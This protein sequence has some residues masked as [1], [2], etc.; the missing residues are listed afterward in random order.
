MSYLTANE[1][2]AV[3]KEKIPKGL[4]ETAHTSEGHFYRHTPT[5]E[6]YASVTTKSGILDAPHL[7]SWA[8]REAVKLITENQNRI[9]ELVNIIENEAP[10]EDHMKTQDELDKIYKAAIMAHKAL[11]EDAGDIGTQGHEA[12]ERY[13]NIWIETGK[14]PQDIRKFIELP[15]SRLH[16]IARSAEQFCIDFEV[17]P[18]ISELFVA[19]PR[20]KF[21]GQLDALMMIPRTVREGK[22]GCAHNWMMSPSRQ[23]I[24]R[25]YECDAKVQMELT[26]VDW[27][28][29]NRVDKP[30]YAMQVSAYWWGFY[31]LTGIRIKNI[32]IVRLDKDKMK[33]EVVKVGN[34]S[35]SFAAFRQVSKVHEWLNDGNDKLISSNKKE[36]ISLDDL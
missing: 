18:V 22:P 24:S 15:D 16:A 9:S 4:V 3:I 32:I 2:R 20:Y 21:A 30:E 14:R 10:I 23:D 19:S 25:C 8:A 6:T 31:E 28:T 34:R 5:G 27:K 29:S 17:L 12:I 33:Y 35:K 13:L 26:L 7:K 11:F 36:S 1:V